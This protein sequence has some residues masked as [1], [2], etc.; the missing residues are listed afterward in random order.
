MDSLVVR[1]ILA[2]LLGAVVYWVLT[3]APIPVFVAAVVGLLV[4]LLVFFGWGSY[5]GG[6]V[7]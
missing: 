7:P 6:R 5:R 2:L 1:L 3:L 4:G